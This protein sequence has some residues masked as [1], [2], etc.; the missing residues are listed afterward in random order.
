MVA[1]YFNWQ[2]KPISQDQWSALYMLER[3]VAKTDLGELG[4]VSTVWLGLN[5]AFDSGPPLIFET[6]IFGGPMDEY[7]DRYSTE[8]E[9]KAGHEFAVQALMFYR[10]EPAKRPVLIHNGRKPRR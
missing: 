5:H 3:H 7:M 10:T 9:A 6:M 2:G 1:W 4:K 8:E